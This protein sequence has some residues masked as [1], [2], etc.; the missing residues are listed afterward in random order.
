MDC[1]DWDAPVRE[2]VRGLGAEQQ[3]R[4]FVGGPAGLLL[5]RCEGAAQREEQW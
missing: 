3:V 5:T 2:G 4:V 1:F